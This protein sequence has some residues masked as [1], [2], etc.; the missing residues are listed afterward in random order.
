VNIFI[1]M[2]TQW[3]VS[4]AGATGLDYNALPVVLRLQQIP[5]ARQA[6]IFEALRIMEETALE[7]MREKR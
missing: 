1:A 3:R 6:E 7:S 5:R 4:Q 2:S